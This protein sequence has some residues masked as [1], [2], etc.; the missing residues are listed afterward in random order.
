MI[1]YKRE[2]LNI[3]YHGIC[4]SFV[5]DNGELKFNSKISKLEISCNIAK[6]IKSFV[7]NRNYI[8]IDSQGEFFDNYLLSIKDI[9]F[10][11]LTLNDS[12]DISAYY[13]LEN[14]T[15]LRLKI[16]KEGCEVKLFK[17]TG[18]YRELRYNLIGEELTVSDFLH[19]LFMIDSGE[20]TVK[21]LKRF[22]P[23]EIYFY[24]KLRDS[25]IRKSELKINDFHSGTLIHTESEIEPRGFIDLIIYD[26][27][28]LMKIIQKFKLSN[29]LLKSII[30]RNFMQ[31]Q[32]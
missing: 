7:D 10:N 14:D 28:S 8:H 12:E 4:D 30:I 20:K 2:G 13:A 18:P 11:Y 22:N 29:E 15:Q 21:I 1:D 23:T 16:K 24:K 25:I 3:Y 6:A 32:V 26:D 17:L 9:I 19:F 31:K 27:A 5:F